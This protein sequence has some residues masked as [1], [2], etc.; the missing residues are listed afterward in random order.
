MGAINGYDW[1]VDLT[2]P[3]DSIES[4]AFGVVVPSL[5]G[6]L[7]DVKNLGNG[8]DGG[9]L[10]DCGNDLAASAGREGRVFESWNFEGYKK[11]AVKA[12]HFNRLSHLPLILHCP[13][14]R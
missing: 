12:Y 4:F 8:T 1:F 7:A 11:D 13:T 2:I 10:S 14:G 9:A 3:I 6:G 5:D